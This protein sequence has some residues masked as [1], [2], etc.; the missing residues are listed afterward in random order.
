MDSFNSVSGKKILLLAPAFF[1]YEMKI[2]SKLEQ[3][4]AY[5]DL[6]DERS[7]TK[8][9][10]RALLKYVPDI[11][12]SKTKKYYDSIIS[13]NL[14][15]N[16]HF[17]FIVKCDM[18]TNEIL[19][20]LRNNYNNAVFC[21]YLWDS[22]KN[23]K[24]VT[25]KFKY[26]DR[27]L[28]FDR[29]DANSNPLIKFRPLF[30]TDDYKKEETYLEHYKYDI[31]FCGTIHSDRYK[32][33]KEVIEKCS[34]LKMKYYMFCYLQSKFVYY[35][36]KLI[37]KEFRHSNKEFFSFDKKASKEISDIIDN[38]KIILDIQHPNQTGLTIRT[39]EM[40]GMNK[41]LIT[42]N[43]EIKHYDFYHPNNI[44]VIDRNNIRIPIEFLEA[45]YEKLDVDIYRKY[46]IEAWIN[47]IL[48]GI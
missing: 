38:S 3:M 46:S 43:A 4:G 32:V 44:L 29:Q 2:K 25:G 45:K 39:I 6:Y 10:N 9:I 31:T 12:N 15:K 27:V 18:I 11:Y 42:T 41:K 36:Y 33:I 24:G 7:V 37:K 47:D 23:I 34:K 48:Y 30:Y 1:G 40:I 28:S 14:E 19:E 22:I 35:I 5:V 16:Y 26:F 21:L 20:K 17:V 13:Q 8:A